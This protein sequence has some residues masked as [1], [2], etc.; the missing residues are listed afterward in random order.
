MKNSSFWEKVE[1]CNH[2]NL[3][4]NYYKAIYCG[5]ED[6]EGSESHC[7]NCGVFITKCQCGSYNG[8]SGWSEKRWK[9]HHDKVY[10]RVVEQY[11]KVNQK[12]SGAASKA[13]GSFFDSGDRDLCLPL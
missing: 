11:R 8:I 10:G 9:K 6:C 4:H 5:T 13:D 3:Y 12:G 1:K 7:V 2:E